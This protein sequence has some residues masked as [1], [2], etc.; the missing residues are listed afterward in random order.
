MIFHCITFVSKL[1]EEC[2]D[3]LEKAL[4]TG[5][6]AEKN[7]QIRHVLQICGDDYSEES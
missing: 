6:I 2:K 1:P 7:F 3:R 5:D 4:Q